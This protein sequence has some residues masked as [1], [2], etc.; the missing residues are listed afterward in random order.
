MTEVS[1]S[2]AV[3]VPPKTCVDKRFPYVVNTLGE[4]TERIVIPTIFPWWVKK[5]QPNTMR[6]VY[7][8]PLQDVEC[9]FTHGTMTFHGIKYKN[10]EQF[11]DY[12]GDIMSM[13]RT[14]QTG[15]STT[16]YKAIVKIP[17]VSH[18]DSDVLA[19][20][21]TNDPHIAQAMAMCEITST[22]G[23]K[24]LFSIAIAGHDF[25]CRAA[26]TYKDNIVTAMVSKL[27]TENASSSV[28][29]MLQKVLQ[30]YER[31]MCVRKEPV[32]RTVRLSGIE[33]LRKQLPDL[34][35]NNYTRECPVLPLIVSFE[36][37][38]RI[39][40]TQSVIL[41]CNQYFTAPSSAHFVGLKRNR[42]SNRDVYPCL[43]TCY[44]QNHLL[45]KG[46]E[47]YRYYHGQHEQITSNTTRP[48][49]KCIKHPS[50]HRKKVASFRHAIELAT[51][52]KVAYNW[53]PHIVR[54]EMWDKSDND[55]MA[56]IQSGTGSIAF[57][58]YEELIGV[59]IHV[60]VI[61][62]GNLES[63]VPR[64]RGKY[65]W[66]PPYPLHVVVF[67]TYKIIYGKE[68]RTYDILTKN[69]DTLFDSTD[70][71]VS[72]LVTNKSM[73]SVRPPVRPLEVV[74]Q[75]ID[76]N[77]KCSAVITKDKT[78]VQVYT[79]PLSV[80]A[81]PEPVCFLDSH[82]R[83]MNTT[84]LSMGMDPVDATKRST[85]DVLYFP[86]DASFMYH[87]RKSESVKAP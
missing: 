73:E 44:L 63:L 25:T 19:D 20:I 36:E 16:K 22:L 67:E 81:V 2:F 78:I 49:P 23:T 15:V 17:T 8:S 80:P 71:V 79:R 64:H 53:F 74:E 61:R 62:D 85:Y 18:W 66:A 33:A 40:H 70:S 38:E 1:L 51:G 35:V 43:V 5:P 29:E 41:Y 72:Y 56:E 31:V 57:R 27:P 24:R 76:R 42:L 11:N 6:F 77:G 10:I 47:T 59:S 84:K 52:T 3:T 65:V 12:I 28:S 39:K 14:E 34:F 55:I 46:S 60:V 75:I 82:I 69:H 37:A 48:L 32:T 87:V 30:K 26:L 83:K 45:R 68:T 58:Y 21:I 7:S 50:Y 9:T 4:H 54:Q 13:L 86:N